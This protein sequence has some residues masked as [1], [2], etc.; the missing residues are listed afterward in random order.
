MVPLLLLAAVARGAASPTDPYDCLMRQLALSY[1]E[2]VVLG[3]SGGW[4]A[5]SGLR[6]HA[7]ALVAQGLRIE[8]CNSSARPSESATTTAS[9]GFSGPE[10]GQALFV[11][12]TG[13]DSAAGTQVH[14]V[15]C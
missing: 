14:K 10:V 9:R 15:I 3:E 2:D 7:L 8:Q 5:G 11:A 4:P 12:T 1:T 13:D 6:Q